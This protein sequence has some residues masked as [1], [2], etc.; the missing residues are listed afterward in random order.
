MVDFSNKG[1]GDMR[2]NQDVSH[3][4]F[5][6]MFNFICFVIFNF[7]AEYAVQKQ[8]GSKNYNETCLVIMKSLHVFSAFK[9]SVVA[10][11]IRRRHAARKMRS[12]WLSQQ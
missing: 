1:E 10:I 11:I 12:D 7:N 5:L 3:I 6:V 9:I 8:K 2:R 4:K